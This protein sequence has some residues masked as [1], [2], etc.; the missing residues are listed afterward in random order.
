MLR[1]KNFMNAR[2]T[3]RDIDALLDALWVNTRVQIL[4]IQNFNAGMLDPQLRKLVDTL[5]SQ[6][7]GW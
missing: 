6:S 7:M 5:V 4:Y 3:P 1:L 2:A